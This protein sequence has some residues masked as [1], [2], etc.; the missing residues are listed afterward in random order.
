[1]TG[2]D[3]RLAQLA[4][5]AGLISDRALAPVAAL[6]A[7]IAATTAARGALADRRAALARDTTDPVLAAL[8][9]RQ[10]ERLRLREA[11]ALSRLARLEA[12]LERAKAA[13]RPAYGRKVALDRLVQETRPRR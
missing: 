11:D 12:E 7:E 2:N 3:P 5:L 8:M 9:A 4:R 13:A 1:V 6:R 10:A